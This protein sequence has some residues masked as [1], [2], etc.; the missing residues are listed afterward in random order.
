[1]C[2]GAYLLELVQS[3]TGQNWSVPPGLSP[4]KCA[5]R[6]I[7][8][9]SPFKP[10]RG[11]ANIPSKPFKMT[12]DPPTIAIL[13]EK[14]AN[15]LFPLFLIF[16]HLSSYTVPPLSPPPPRFSCSTLEI[17][18]EVKASCWP[19][20]SSCCCLSDCEERNGLRQHPSADTGYR[21]NGLWSH[22]AQRINN[23]SSY[24]ACQRLQ[25]HKPWR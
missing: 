3:V 18:R 12:T 23:I 22:P 9:F 24:F 13:L 15:N 11:R 20:S 8:A 10:L 14:K 6:K 7:D 19:L 25:M 21:V 17:T 2:A 16:P 5:E 1:M 4:L